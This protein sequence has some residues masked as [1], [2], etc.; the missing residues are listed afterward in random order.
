VSTSPGLILT[1]RRAG[2]LDAFVAVG[3]P[4]ADVTLWRAE[5]E[6]RMVGPPLPG[7]PQ[8]WAYDPKAARSDRL[9]RADA[10]EALPNAVAVGPDG[11]HAAAILHLDGLDGAYPAGWVFRRRT[12]RRAVSV[13]VI[14]ARRS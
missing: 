8:P 1:L 13:V 12:R 14:A 4:S 9:G 5:A 6:V 7:A 2:F 10:P 11:V 3:A